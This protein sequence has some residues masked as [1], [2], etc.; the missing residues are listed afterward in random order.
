MVE[1]LVFLFSKK[2]NQLESILIY[3]FVR[4]LSVLSWL[5]VGFSCGPWLIEGQ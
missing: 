4:P 3:Y 5:R 1:M 2:L